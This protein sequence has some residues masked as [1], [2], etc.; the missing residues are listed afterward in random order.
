MR[1]SQSLSIGHVSAGQIGRVAGNDGLAPGTKFAGGPRAGGAKRSSGAAKTPGGRSIDIEVKMVEIGNLIHRLG[2]REAEYS[3]LCSELI[4]SDG[5][6][7]IAIGLAVDAGS[8][9]V[10]KAA[11]AEE[12]A[13]THKSL[14]VPR[15]KY[16]A[17]S[18]LAVILGKL[19]FA[20]SLRR[21]ARIA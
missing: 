20:I 1:R 17:A 19:P 10:A 2:D 9:Q 15:E 13:Q 7:L 16:R 6:G 14:A 4:G 18:S 3:L 21:S 12:V 8:D 5:D 11:A